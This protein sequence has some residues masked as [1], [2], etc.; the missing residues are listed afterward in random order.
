MCSN[1]FDI[2]TF[3]AVMTTGINSGQVRGPVQL[4]IARSI[5]PILPAELSITRIAATNESES[6]SKSDN[7][8]MGRK[9]IVPY[10]LYRMHG[11]ISAPLADTARGGTGFSE[12][13]LDLLWEALTNMFEN[14]RSAARGEMVVRGL[15]VFRHDSPYGNAMAHEIFERVTVKRIFEDEEYEPGDPRTHSLPPAR[16]FS[17][18][19]VHLDWDSPPQGVTMIRKI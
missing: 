15:V 9:H 11:Y 18:Y 12:A 2:R 7:R 19:R 17:D 8:T 10:G 4:K 5:E 3:G 13:D 6:G 14:D 16:S 1:F